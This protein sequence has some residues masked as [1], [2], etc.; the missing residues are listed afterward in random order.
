MSPT[1]RVWLPPHPSLARYT[2]YL[3]IELARGL[4]KAADQELREAGFTWPDFLVLTIVTAVDGL[5]QEA[6]C[7]RTGVDRSTVSG[8]TRDLEHEGLLD[9][10]ND[11]LDGRQVTCFATPVGAAAAAEAARAM[12]RTA[13]TQLRLL[14]TRE[15][16]RLHAL[17]ARA[18][19]ARRA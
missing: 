14:D 16:A 4:R 9:R 6:V 19:G 8:I 17:L 11:G 10:R 7:D 13:R 2:P 15:R 1:R 3:A 5:A 18:L 12:D